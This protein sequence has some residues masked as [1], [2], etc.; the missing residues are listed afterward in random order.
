MSESKRFNFEERGKGNRRNHST[1]QTTKNNIEVVEAE[2]V[3]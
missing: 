2:V 3:E 1:P